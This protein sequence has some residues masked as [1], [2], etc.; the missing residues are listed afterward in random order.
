M[1]QICLGNPPGFLHYFLYCSDQIHLNS[2]V[3]FCLSPKTTAV[4][5]PNKVKASEEQQWPFLG[6]P[7][8]SP[9]GLFP[10]L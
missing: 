4:R 3:R 2:W 1:E 10:V 9:S 7:K 5:I 6:T 8:L